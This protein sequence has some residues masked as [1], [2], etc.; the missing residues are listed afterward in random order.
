MYPAKGQTKKPERRRVAAVEEGP[1]R[2]DLAGLALENGVSGRSPPHL[3]AR[4]EVGW[5]SAQ[6]P[7]GMGL[8]V[9]VQ[10]LALV[11]VLLLSTEA[12]QG[13]LC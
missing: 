13:P 10:A 7:Q 1:K 5:R 11:R 2:N 12:V 6:R 9:S 4:S 8:E 3:F